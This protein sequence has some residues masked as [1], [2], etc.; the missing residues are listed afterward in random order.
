MAFLLAA[1][2]T[3]GRGLAGNL[4]YAVFGV[5]SALAM[6]GVGVWD[7]TS[8]YIAGVH[9]FLLFLFA[10]WNGYSSWTSLRVLLAWR[11]RAQPSIHESRFQPPG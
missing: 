11:A 6:I 7:L 2:V 9:P 5:L 1:L 8:T 4:L 3:M 10:A